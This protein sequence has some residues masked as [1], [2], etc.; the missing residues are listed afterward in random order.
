MAKVLVTLLG[1]Y[2]GEMPVLVVINKLRNESLSYMFSHEEVGAFGNKKG[3]NK[4]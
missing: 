3:V 2:V 4:W 1:C